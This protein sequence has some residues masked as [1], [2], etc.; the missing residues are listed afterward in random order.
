MESQTSIVES[1]TSYKGN[2][3]TIFCHILLSS[4]NRQVGYGGCRGRGQGGPARFC[5]P[6]KFCQQVGGIRWARVHMHCRATRVTYTASL[7][8]LLAQFLATVFHANASTVASHQTSSCPY[9]PDLLHKPILTAYP[10]LDRPTR[11][12]VLSGYIDSIVDK[13]LILPPRQV[14]QGSEPS[15]GVRSLESSVAAITYHA[16]QL[17]CF[18]LPITLSRQ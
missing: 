11:A 15:K 1:R 9:A 16:P 3:S 4:A 18:A 17:C 2:Y 13:V 7:P 8:E 12:S 10:C 14:H 6:A 5:H